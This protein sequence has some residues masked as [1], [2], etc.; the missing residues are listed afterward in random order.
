MN[1]EILKLISDFDKLQKERSEIQTELDKEIR[2]QKVCNTQN[3]N[4]EKKLTEKMERRDEM[5]CKYK[6][7]LEGKLA[8]L[9]DSIVLYSSNRSANLECNI[10]GKRYILF[11]TGCFLSQQA[12]EDNNV[13]LKEVVDEIVNNK[14]VFDK[15]NSKDADLLF[16]LNKEI[17]K[18][19]PLAKSK[20]VAR[21]V[22]LEQQKI[23]REI[24]KTK[25][26]I[27][28]NEEM[29][30]FHK[31][32]LEGK[33]FIKDNLINRIVKS[34]QLKAQKM[35][36]CLLNA[37]QNDKALLEGYINSL[38]DTQSIE[39]DAV[40]YVDEQLEKL[41][42]HIEILEEVDNIKGKL[43]SYSRRYVAPIQEEVEQQKIAIKSSYTMQ[44]IH[45]AKLKRNS[46]EIDDLLISRYQDQEL[47]DKLLNISKKDCAPEQWKT[48]SLI[49]HHYDGYVEK[50]LDNLVG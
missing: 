49:K 24:E 3:K 43:E 23:E 6:G 13:L 47:V 34:N 46:E 28:Q 36:K 5:L 45:K 33:P 48:I 44:D 35:V 25:Q 16:K 42:A 41:S 21:E 10:F 30:D 14:V 18:N 38:A 1:R 20:L 19:P 22:K 29:L 50:K 39:S 27:A 12:A 7:E 2:S 11:M 9:M 26:E 15:P 40:L 37:I 4:S 17:K 8:E 32:Q 31:S